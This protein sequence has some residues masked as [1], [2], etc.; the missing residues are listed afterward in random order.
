MTE[1][2][3]WSA[4]DSDV[5]PVL[6]Q[7]VRYAQQT[8]PSAREARSVQRRVRRA[9]D[10]PS[11]L[12]RG[13]T[14]RIRYQ[15]GTWGTVLGITTG[16]AG[17]AFAGYGLKTVLYRHS[18]IARTPAVQSPASRIMT[19]SGASPH[20][21]GP[22]ASARLPESLPSSMGTGSAPSVVAPPP[23]SVKPQP[24]ALSLVDEATLLAKARRLTKSDPSAV[25]RLTREHARR[26]PNSALL[27]EREALRIEALLLLDRAAEAE[28]ALS[29]FERRFPVSPYRRRLRSLMSP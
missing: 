10:E 1:P 26:F 22:A 19:S 7:L 23:V 14:T 16:L 3:R 24:S 2:I 17:A 8:G 21:T 11:G 25:L 9:M 13:F 4:P 12:R 15:L 18:V 20:R 29:T 5:D 28:L 27:E 6:R